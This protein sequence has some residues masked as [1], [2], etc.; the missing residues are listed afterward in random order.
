MPTYN[1]KCKYCGK[2]HETSAITRPSQL[3]GLIERFECR[4]CGG[5]ECHNVPMGGTGFQLSQRDLTGRVDSRGFSSRGYC[6]GKN[7]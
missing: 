2:E 5:K 7:L 3:P 4:K 6:L 1:L